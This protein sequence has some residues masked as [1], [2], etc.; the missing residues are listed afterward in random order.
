MD[1]RHV[2]AWR[3]RCR[4]SRAQ[5]GAELGISAHTIKS[6]ELGKRHVPAPTAALMKTVEQRLRPGGSQAGAA[7][8]ILGGAALIRLGAGPGYVAV[9]DS[10][11][12]GRATLAVCQAHDR[13]AE[14][15]LTRL[16]QPGGRYG[17]PAELAGLGLSWRADTAAEVVFWLPVF[18][19]E[20]M[21]EAVG[22]FAPERTTTQVVVPGAADTDTGA[23][24]L[25]GEAVLEAVLGTHDHVALWQ[26]RRTDQVLVAGAY[27]AHGDAIEQADDLTRRSR[28]DVAW[29]WTGP[30]RHVVR[31][32]SGTVLYDGHDRDSA[33]AVA[34]AEALT[35]HDMVGGP[36][37]A[38]VG[39]PSGAEWDPVE[40]AGS[41]STDAA[42]T[43]RAPART[44]GHSVPK[45]ADPSAPSGSVR[46]VSAG[47]AD[48]H[49][50]H[51]RGHGREATAVGRGRR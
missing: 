38:P 27:V 31:D 24:T 29:V 41:A 11:A 49:P 28:A 30:G 35:R 18:P 51:G 20:D 10:G 3:R 13:S 21:I 42:P 23:S 43:G 16:T 15:V 5:A 25:L 33:V 47:A 36:T 39:P 26:R 48:E 50:P 44:R 32:S 2:V 4:L 40:T 1:P 7:I 17:T 9:E 6:Y 12:L 34:V 22:A 37:S 8:R 46:L 14:L 45:S 19:D